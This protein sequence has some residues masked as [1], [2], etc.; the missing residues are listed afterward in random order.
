MERTSQVADDQPRLGAGLLLGV[1]LVYLL[2]EVLA[3]AAALGANTEISVTLATVAQALPALVGA[4]VIAGAAAGL[5]LPTRSPLADR[6]RLLAGGVAGA[7]IGLVVGGGILLTFGASGGVGVLAATL[8]VAAVLGGLAAALP[9]PVLASGLAAIVGCLAVAILISIFQ[10]PLATVLGG[11]TSASNRFSGAILLGIVESV[12]QGIVAAVVATRYLRARDGGRPWPWYLLAG[13]AYGVVGLATL[14]ISRI[15]GFGLY[16]QVSGFSAD[17][18]AYLNLLLQSSLRGA[19]VA[20]FVGGI[21][22][23]IVVG[24]SMSRTP[25]AAS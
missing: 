17:D 8:L 12:I 16:R 5:W 18:A 1:A 23:V 13:A 19:L 22:A 20:G 3:S 2:A 4:T 7:A 25:D 6:R 15:G 24:R 11:G 21:G 9:P 10:N 14:A